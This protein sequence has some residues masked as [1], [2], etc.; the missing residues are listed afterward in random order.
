MMTKTGAVRLLVLITLVFFALL[1][2][3]PVW[4]EADDEK[5]ELKKAKE[6][7]LKLLDELDKLERE[8][9]KIENRL[10]EIQAQSDRLENK[11][12]HD[13]KQ[14]KNLEKIQAEQE[15]M[16]YQRLRALHRQK[17]AGLVQVLIDSGSIPE[18]LHSYR[19]LAA[20]LSYDETL[21]KEYEQR[22]RELEAKVNQVKIESAKLDRLQASL[23]SDK[24]DL[25][26]VRGDKTRLLMKAHQRKQTYLALIEAQEKSRR[27]LIKEVIIKDEDSLPDGFEDEGDEKTDRPD[28]VWPDFAALKGR[29]PCPVEGE[30]KDHF[31]KNPGLFGTYT[32]RQGITI[33]AESGLSVRAI[34]AGEI[35]FADWLKGYGHVV[36]INHGRRYYTLTAGLTQV[37]PLVGQ[38]VNQGTILGIV[39]GS[40]KKNKKR[41][42]LEIRY[43]GQALDPGQWL[44]SGRVSQANHR[45]T[46]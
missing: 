9:E 1:S 46:R 4:T 32:T 11:L 37:K 36:I 39:P 10:V 3:G 26:Q 15:S 44:D 19:Y 24:A 13:R 5:Q 6:D 21:L 8:I 2:A 31:G 27:Q 23:K 7:E 29:F 18:L 42:Y 25:R 30:I 35:V 22:R 17:G 28:R 45:E 33:L 16:L 12:T 14:I 34:S 40:G 43:R 41:I 20:I 38:W